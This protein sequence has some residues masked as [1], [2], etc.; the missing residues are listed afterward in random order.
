[1]RHLNWKGIIK[2]S[3]LADNMIFYLENPKDSTK[4][5]IEQIN[6][7]S[8]VAE[9]EINKSHQLNFCLLKINSLE[10]KLRNQSHL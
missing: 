9:Y 5:L 4:K 10:E 1:M 7:F 3:F 8:E 2:L 6:E